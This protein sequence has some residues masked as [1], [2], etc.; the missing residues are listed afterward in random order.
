MQSASPFFEKLHRVQSVLPYAELDPIFLAKAIDAAPIL[1]KR[2]CD[3]ASREFRPLENEEIS[4]SLIALSDQVPAI[5]D[6]L[7]S[8]GSFTSRK[9]SYKINP[10]GFFNQSIMHDSLWWKQTS[11]TSGPPLDVIY[12]NSF[13]F[14]QLFHT[15]RRVLFRYDAQVNR[16]DHYLASV[17]AL[18]DN[19][20]SPD[21][22]WPDPTDEFRSIIQLYFSESDLEQN[23]SVLRCLNE[24]RPETVTLKPSILERLASL[25]LLRHLDC[26]YILCS[27]SRL[28]GKLRAAASQVA[29]PQIIEAYG[30]TEAAIFAS[31]CRMKKGMHVDGDVRV[32]VLDDNGHTSRDGSGTLFITTSRNTAMPLLRYETGDIVEVCANQCECGRPTPRIKKVLGRKLKNFVLP[33]GREVSP[34]NFHSVFSHFPLQ[35]VQFIQKSPHHFLLRIQ[36]FKPIDDHRYEAY[37]GSILRERVKITLERTFFATNANRKFQRYIREF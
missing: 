36:E 14:E 3:W 13:H 22:I 18:H 32:E 15:V 5:S 25:D 19:P 9:Q 21:C 1:E 2:W 16:R 20:R 11:G 24:L 33:S 12:E 37:I 7:R 30:L 29:G 35:E 23:R 8:D 27:G 31:E 6:F 28:S 4:G 34:S 26:S 10:L 17:A